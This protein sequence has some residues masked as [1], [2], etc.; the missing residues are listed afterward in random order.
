MLI[1]VAAVVVL[2]VASNTVA[3]AA[4]AGF[5]FAVIAVAVVDS[6]GSGGD[7]DVLVVIHLIVF[8]VLPFARVC[9]PLFTS[10]DL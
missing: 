6:N 8:C 3:V 7:V 10:C 9:T 5:D 1:S 4:V 2:G